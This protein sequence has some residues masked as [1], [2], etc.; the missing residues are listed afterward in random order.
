MICN[1]FILHQK[2][3][4]HKYIEIVNPDWHDAQSWDTFWH[5][6]ITSLKDIIPQWE[7]IADYFLY[8]DNENI[9]NDDKKAFLEKLTTLKESGEYIFIDTIYGKMQ[10]KVYEAQYTYLRYGESLSTN[11]EADDD[12]VILLEKV[13]GLLENSPH[14]TKLEEKYNY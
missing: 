1:G 3:N 4:S 14:F 10:L 5:I 6:L 11:I 13:A 12:N 2:D 8:T 9:P 7:L